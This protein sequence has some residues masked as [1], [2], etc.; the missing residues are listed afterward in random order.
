MFTLFYKLFS[1]TIFT[2]LM[3]VC[4]F[5]IPL[6]IIKIFVINITQSHTGK[7]KETYEIKTFKLSS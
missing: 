6:T 2:V 3:T 7:E 5:H 4:T 1:S